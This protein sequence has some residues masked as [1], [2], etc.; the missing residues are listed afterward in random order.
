MSGIARNKV[1]VSKELIKFSQAIIY[2]DHPAEKVRANQALID[3]MTPSLVIALVDELVQMNIPLPELKTGINKLL[4][5][6]NKSLSNYSS[7]GIPEGSF[8]DY[9][10]QNNL[11]MEKR[12]K[13]LRPLIRK[14]NENRRDLQVKNELLYGFQ[15]LEPF[16]NHYVIKENVLFPLLEKKWPD[17]RCLQVMWSFHDDI[18]SNRKKIISKLKKNELKL[19]QFNKLT[20]DLFFNMLAIKFR[21]EKIIFPEILNSITN[22]DL[23]VMLDNSQEF[24]YPYIQPEFS[25]EKPARKASKPANG[26]NLE[27]GIL[28]A[29]QI[30]LIFNHLP[31]DITFVDEHNKVRFY[32]TPKKRIFPRAKSVIGRD[33]RNCHPP[34]SV[35]IVEE[36]ISEFRKGRQG[37]ASFWI[38]LGEEYVLIQYFAVRDNKDNY[39]GVVEVS[40]DISDI[41]KIKG[42][43]RLLNWSK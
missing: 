27:T 11:E 9:L 1:Q 15:E 34:E 10:Q 14:I 16:D 17:Y 39:C 22:R 33:V 30:K 3:G 23:N 38:M 37:K 6:F 25:N 2:A 26:V 20:G 13:K 29:K 12:L 31:V 19:E 7:P 8:L 28:T 41:K 32:S 40:Q 35:H 4:N 24:R 36:I 5:L 18:R 43:Q 42:E 21:E